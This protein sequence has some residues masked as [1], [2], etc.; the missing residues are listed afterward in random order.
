MNGSQVDARWV[1][2]CR[3]TVLRSGDL[4]KT[5]YG[6]EL[7]LPQG[8]KPEILDVD[9][10]LGWEINHAPRLEAAQEES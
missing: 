2:L 8:R 6:M 10:G 5:P 1:R 3:G 4:I 7:A 9:P